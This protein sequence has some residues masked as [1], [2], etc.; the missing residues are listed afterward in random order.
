MPSCVTQEQIDTFQSDG[1]VLIKGLF[2]DHVETLRAGIE[3]NMAEPGPFAAE[4]LKAGGSSMITATGRASRNSRMSSGI[5]RRP[6]L[7]LI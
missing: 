5:H 1:V 7:R 4:N 6:R 3:R 2:A